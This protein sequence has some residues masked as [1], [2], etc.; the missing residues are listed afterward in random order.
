MP[1]IAMGQVTQTR[2]QTSRIRS[3]DGK[4]AMAK[5]A[6]NPATRKPAI[7]HIAV[8]YFI[9]APHNRNDLSLS[10]PGVLTVATRRLHK[11]APSVRWERCE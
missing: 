4:V 6:Q 9:G 1:A 10:A 7:A 5:S 3:T 2:V 11:L 8:R